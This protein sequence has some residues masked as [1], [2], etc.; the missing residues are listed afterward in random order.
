[1][2]DG[3]RSFNFPLP[4][5]SRLRAGEI[6]VDLFAG[7]GGASEALKQAL[8]QDPALAYNHDALAIGMHAANHP[9]TSHH[10]EDIW[11]A[12]PR[13]DVARRPIGWFHASPDCTH[14]SQAKGGQ[15]RSRKT[16]ALSWVVLKWIGML[17]RAD[18][19]NGTSTA[20]RIFSMENVWQILTW[21]PLIA[22][23]CKSTGRVLKMDG[24][25]A[26]TGERVPV[27]HQQLVP[28][29]SRTGRTWRQFVA[30]LRAL[31][32][33][34]EW[35]KLVASD[36]GA[37]TSRE[38][39]FL[40]GRR[41]GEPIVWP[42]AS[43]G[44]A[45]GQ[46]PRVSA[47]DCLDFSIPC[48]SIF[49]RKRPLADAT[50]RRIAKGTMRHVIQ[51]ADPFIVPVTHQGADR[52]HDVH[53]PLRTITAANRGELMLAMP[54][55]APFITE[56]ANASTQRTMAASDPLRTMC[57]G[58]KGGHFSVVTP[59]LAGVGGRAG[60]SEPRS[61]GEPLYT[62]TTKADTALVA[63][64]LVK[65]RGD[66]IGTPATEPVP[67]I[68]SGA[69]AARPAGA[70]HA[71]G[72]SAATLVTLRNNM[73]GADPQE[74]LSTI[75]AQGEHH[76]LATAFLEQANGGFYE[77]GGRD[78][79]DPVSTITATGSQ[80]QLVTADLA[81]LSPEH[82]EGALRVA[83]FLVKYYGTGANVPSLTDPADTIT[84]K[85]R[86]ALVTV[87][88]KGTPY[89]IVDIGLRMLKPHELYRAQ[90]FPAGY[91]IDRTANGTPLTTSAAVRMVG[92]SVSPP[93]LRA[94]AE[95]NLD[96]VALP[97]AEAA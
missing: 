78:A 75:A 4:Q 30:A 26:A 21:G 53:E 5:R 22:K 28:D 6:V 19:V 7:G 33:V 34:V 39:L 25:V 93:P 82:Q 8:G 76:A 15:P 73:A 85:D 94:L 27:E 46:K 77:G 84:T 88:I 97:L 17:L 24:T 23:R 57:A 66:S 48:P 86:L 45:A 2:A 65:F 68:T 81:K 83:A 63:P 56:H 55:L 3:S 43:H 9:L 38:R 91:I 41:D 79:R 60:Q 95:A 71:L 89:V 61:G 12:D 49:G 14:F 50:M 11:H 35:R 87:V 62:M 96:P 44:T 36:F 1:M 54:E 67:T 52:V 29:K 74:P 70:A 92:N 72:V 59:I 18:L 10:R 16:R 64:H 47:A 37:G 42:A 31:G 40:L 90:G 69:G 51:S 80:Q 13:V 32:Y 58:V 20:P